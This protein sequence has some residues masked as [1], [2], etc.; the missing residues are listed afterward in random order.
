MGVELAMHSMLLMSVHRRRHV[1]WWRGRRRRWLLVLRVVFELFLVL[2]LWALH[3]D[4]LDFSEVLATLS[5]ALLLLAAAEDDTDNDAKTTASADAAT[6]TCMVLAALF[7]LVVLGQAVLVGPV[8]VV[9]ITVVLLVG[10]SIIRALVG[11]IAVISRVRVL[12]A[13]AFG[14]QRCGLSGL[15]CRPLGGCRLC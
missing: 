1:H 3:I 5:C 9:G 15:L 8:R 14:A 12:C 11:P 13:V 2:F 7:A 10:I 4:I 6:D